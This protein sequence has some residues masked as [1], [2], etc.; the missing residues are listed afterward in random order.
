MTWRPKERIIFLGNKINNLRLEKAKI[1][2]KIRI[3]ERELDLLLGNYIDNDEDNSIT[4][5]V[6]ALFEASPDMELNA[7]YVIAALGFDKNQIPSIRTILARSVRHGIIER[8]DN[9]WGYYKLCEK[10]ETNED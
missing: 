8:I 2:K 6:N 1:K 4:A 5:Q 10:R 3:L 9:K 7:N